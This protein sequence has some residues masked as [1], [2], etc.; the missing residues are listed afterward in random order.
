MSSKERL[1]F[2]ASHGGT[3]PRCD[4]PDCKSHLYKRLKSH[5]L[6]PNNTI[7]VAAVQSGKDR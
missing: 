4:I 3:T 5:T 1:R 2:P 7:T 6:C